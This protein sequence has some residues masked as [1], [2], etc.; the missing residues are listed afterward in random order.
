VSG[1]A[2]GRP[3]AGVRLTRIKERSLAL[4]E[5]TPTWRLVEADHD[6]FDAAGS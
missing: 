4:I 5:N 1:D 6:H 2:C 3:G